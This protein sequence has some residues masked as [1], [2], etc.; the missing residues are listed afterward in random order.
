[1]RF[2]DDN[3]PLLLREASVPYGKKNRKPHKHN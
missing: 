1:M 2:Q 3:Q